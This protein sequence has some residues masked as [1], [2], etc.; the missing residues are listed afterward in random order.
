MFQPMWMSTLFV[1]CY[2]DLHP[3]LNVHYVYSI[4]IQCFELHGRRYKE[5]N[6]VIFPTAPLF[7][8]HHEMGHIIIHV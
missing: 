5:A 3:Y 8:T 2:I 6:K 7:S 1:A 4:V